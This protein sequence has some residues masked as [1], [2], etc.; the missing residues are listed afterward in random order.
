MYQQQQ[1]VYQHQ[2]QHQTPT[3]GQYKQHYEEPSQHANMHVGYAPSQQ[4]KDPHQGETVDGVPLYADVP[5][6]ADGKKRFINQG[7]KDVPCGLFFVLFLL[8]A[9]GL[10]AYGFSKGDPVDWSDVRVVK[11]TANYT[12]YKNLPG[13]D[14]PDNGL[15][16]YANTSGILI[17]LFVGIIGAV[18]WCFGALALMRQYPVQYIWT[19]TILLG[20]M[21]FVAGIVFIATGLRV[22]SGLIFI[23]IGV[24]HLL[25]I[26]CVKSRIPFAAMLLETACTIV[27]KWKAT[28][29]VAISQIFVLALYLFLFFVAC[30]PWAGEVVITKDAVLPGV[31]PFQPLGYVVETEN[32]INDANIGLLLTLVFITFWTCQVIANVVHVTS[33]G[34]AATWYFY[35]A[36]GLPR[37]ATAKSFKRATTTSFGSICFGSLLVAIMKMIKFLLR[38][39][40]DRRS[41]LFCIVLCLIQCI[42]DLMRYFNEWAFVQ[43]AVYGK[44]YIQAAKQTWAMLMD[45]TVWG[46][47]IA[48]CLVDTAIQ[49]T[50]IVLAAITGLVF[51]LVTQSI[52][53]AV[54]AALAAFMTSSVMMGVINSCVKTIFVCYTDSQQML[55]TI[56]PQLAQNIGSVLGQK[57]ASAQQQQQ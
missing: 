46:G 3:T 31:D 25:W 30:K 20:V 52:L 8:G 49:A 41:P 19:F 14:V 50:N 27:F 38:M 17:G 9:F 42:E 39:M 15:D 1:D 13:S 34:V 32:W 40:E 10:A 24:I 37:N 35:S 23:L 36:T 53:V 22:Q 45:G 4:Y 28:L 21:F 55:S 29:A 33:C 51:W 2:Q 57:E 44:T 12:Y 11:E 47:V 5:I 18:F 6:P 48:D 7:W 54:I 43:V 16:E 26:M 56:A